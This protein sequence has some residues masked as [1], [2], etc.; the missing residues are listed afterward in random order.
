MTETH[1]GVKG[2][3]LIVDDNQINRKLLEDILIE[4]G[5]RVRTSDVSK[6]ALKSIKTDPPDLIL[7]DIKMP[8]MDGYEVCRQLRSN[9][10][11]INIPIIFIN[12]L[13]DEESK[14]KSFEAGGVDYITKPFQ[15]HEILA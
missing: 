15:A 6:N 5:L 11:T 1:D 13:E 9:P 14:T 3:L 12:T 8:G 7:L 10:L 2:D 4:D